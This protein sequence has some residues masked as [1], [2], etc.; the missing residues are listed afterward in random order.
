MALLYN[1]VECKS[2]QKSF[3]ECHLLE[4]DDANTNVLNAT[5]QWCPTPLAGFKNF[6]KMGHYKYPATYFHVSL[7]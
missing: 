7:Y 2:I 6:L 3:F 1:V 4:Q 5:G